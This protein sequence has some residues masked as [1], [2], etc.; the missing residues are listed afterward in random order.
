MKVVQVE[1]R[2][3]RDVRHRPYVCSQCECR[4]VGNLEPGDDLESAYKELH[5]DAVIIV[6]E[7][8]E[9]EKENYRKS[10]KENK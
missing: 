10:L 5:E 7:M 8:V 2:V 3:K 9:T 1:V 6:E 4:L